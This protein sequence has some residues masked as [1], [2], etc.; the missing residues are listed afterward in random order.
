MGYLSCNAESAVAT[1]DTY[2]WPELKN[3]ANKIR[4]R[5]NKQLIKK[6]REFS[7]DELAAATD[8]FSA[9]SFLGKGSHGSVHRAVLDDGKLIAAVKKTKQPS[10]STPTTLHHFKF[11]AASCPG[12]CTTPAENEIEILSRVQHPRLVNLLGFCTDSMDRKLIVVEY[13]PNG[14]LYDLLHSG[15]SRPPGWTRR[16]RFGY[17]VAKAVHAL[18]T[19]NPPVIHRD[20]K[21]SNVLIDHD[22][23]ARLGDFGLSLRGHV[24]DVLVQCTPPAGTLGYLDPGY[25]A[26]GD[27]TAK[28]DVF[29]FGILLLEII[30][31]RNAI[32]V[33]YSPPS[34]VDWAV[35]VI[36]RGD[37]A[38]ICDRRIGPPANPALIR[39]LAV[40]AARCVRSTAEKRPSM[41][42]VVECLKVV[43]KRAHAPPIWNNFRQRVKCVENKEPLLCHREVYDV[44]EIDVLKVLET[45]AAGQ[46]VSRRDRKISSGTASGAQSGNGTTFSYSN[47]INGSRG[48][49]STTTITKVERVVRSKSIGSVNE[50]EVGLGPEPETSNSGPSA[51]GRRSG[52]TVK[53]APAVVR[54]SKSRSLGGSR[55]NSQEQQ[56]QQR[57]VVQRY[58]LEFERDPSCSSTEFDMSKLVISLDDNSDRKML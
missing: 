30:S 2:N 9:E 43:R 28:S 49:A 17:Q 40:L 35:P 12:N 56:Q 21:S 33:N 7:Y 38:G 27:L 48:T 16:V 57:V 13:M 24:E 10:N 58:V 15:S 4:R 41:V 6:I 46:G 22:G 45:A 5:P 51:G 8:G 54:L 42:E 19:S 18:H 25:L 53:M 37:Y 1:C 55:S 47:N 34:I 31:G 50:I 23:D 52:V 36:K 44:S 20:I 29:S 14:S 39:Q 3:K 11:N 32:D 26:P